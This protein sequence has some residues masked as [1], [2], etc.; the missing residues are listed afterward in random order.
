VTRQSEYF[1]SNALLHR[2]SYQHTA[3]A[4][5]GLGKLRNDV[6]NEMCQTKSNRSRK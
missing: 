2:L 5:I 3:S 6:R 1:Q 4:Y